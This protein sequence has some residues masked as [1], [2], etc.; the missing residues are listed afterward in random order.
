M[1]PACVFCEL[2]EPIEYLYST[3]VFLGWRHRLIRG[4]ENP[5]KGTTF[6]KPELSTAFYQPPSALS[7]AFK[8]LICKGKFGIILS[9]ET[10][11]RRRKQ[12]PPEAA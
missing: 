11:L 3:S 9:M 8:H 6:L 5:T 12:T 1:R 4:S 10:P 7:T 2:L